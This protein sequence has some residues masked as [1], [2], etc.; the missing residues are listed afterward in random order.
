MF[1]PAQS[2]ITRILLSMHQAV[3]I[4]R[5][6]KLRLYI[7]SVQIPVCKS[8]LTIKLVKIEENAT[9]K[10]TDYH[11][12][13][14]DCQSILIFT[15]GHATCFDYGLDFDGNQNNAEEINANIHQLIKLKSFIKQENIF[16]AQVNL[17][18][19]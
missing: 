19:M 7:N 17:T 15:E 13:A 12:P 3:R 5:Y 4:L 18:I 6:I 8:Q 1:R 11:L 9:N 14:I 10:S 16:T 2:Q